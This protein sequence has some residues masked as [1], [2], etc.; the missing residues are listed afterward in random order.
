MTRLADRLP[1]PL[2][3]PILI[4]RSLI[5]GV[6]GNFAA[7]AGEVSARD[8]VADIDTSKGGSHGH[9]PARRYVQWQ[10]EPSEA[11]NERN[12]NRGV[13]SNHQLHHIGHAM[14]RAWRRGRPD[15]PLYL[16]HVSPRIAF[17]RGRVHCSG[18]STAICSSGGPML[19]EDPPDLADNGG[20][21]LAQVAAR[22][23]QLGSHLVEVRA[24]VR[25]QAVAPSG[26]GR[27]APVRD[28]GMGLDRRRE[29]ELV[30]AHEDWRLPL[31]F[32]DAG[33]QGLA[34]AFR[35]EIRAISGQQPLVG[36]PQWVGE[37]DEP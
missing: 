15:V 18:Y 26:P 31:Q 21:V 9:R 11:C 5:R 13:V 25:D 10:A 28:D 27:V 16:A 7:R 20:V 12:P 3:V 32:V 36:R 23:E 24:V 35:E 4:D 6:T 8:R 29:P 37:A 33:G 17:P 2:T 30:Q 14:A 1:E 34:E 19:R 22:H